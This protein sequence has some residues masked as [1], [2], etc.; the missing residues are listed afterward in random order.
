MA[1]LDLL[2]H[3]DLQ[4]ELVNLDLVAS[5]VLLVHLVLLVYQAL[6][7]LQVNVVQQ[8]TL[9]QGEILVILEVEVYLVDLD[10]LVPLDSLVVVVY[11]VLLDHRVGL[12]Y[13]APLVL[14]VL[15]VQL[16]KQ[17]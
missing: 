13:L 10:H 8:E 14:G 17:V 5:Q 9:D 12:V 16:E 11:Q 3:W 15:V 4:V 2:D 7:D 1:S 6:E